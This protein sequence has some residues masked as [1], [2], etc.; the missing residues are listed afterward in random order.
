M[1]DNIYQNL[2]IGLVCAIVSAFARMIWNYIKQTDLSQKPNARSKRTALHTQFV[3][4]LFLSTFLIPIAML[5]HA[6]NMLSALTK[7]S[8]FLFAGF[9]FIGAWG[10][11]DA[12]LAFYP[13]DESEKDSPSEDESDDS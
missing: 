10:A 4:F 9:S 7:V 12:A 13:E 1:L 2:F 3:I 5:I 11:F 6:T 8:F